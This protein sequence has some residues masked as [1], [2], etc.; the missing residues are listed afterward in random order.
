MPIRPLPLRP[1]RARLLTLLCAGIALLPSLAPAQSTTPA[2]LEAEMDRWIALERRTADER[3]RWRSAKQVL[4]TS[5]EVL[6]KERAALQEQAGSNELSATLFKNRLDLVQRGTESHETAHTRLAAAIDTFEPRL[7]ALLPRLPDPLREKIDPL[8]RR[9]AAEAGGESSSLSERAQTLVAALSSIDQFNN[10]LTLRHQL[11]DDG[12][13]RT[14]DVRVLYWGL[15]VAYAIDASGRRAWILSPG[16]EGWTWRPSDGDA[17]AI[18]K[19]LD[20][21]D[22]QR[23]PELVVLPVAGIG[24]GE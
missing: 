5:L 8:V 7:R 14:I 9:L 24:G 6:K 4:E 19:L 20:V 11:R 17:V 1:E 23:S 12:N 22:K 2:D 16:A 10:T 3:N 21:H 18:A 13:G 15:T